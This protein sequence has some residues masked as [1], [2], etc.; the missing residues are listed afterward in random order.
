MI[1]LTDRFKEVNAL[2]EKVPSYIALFESK[3]TLRAECSTSSD[4]QSHNG[5]QS[6]DVTSSPGSVLLNRPGGI[7]QSD[8]SAGD[9]IIQDGTGN[10]Q[11]LWQSFTAPD[12]T[13]LNRVAFLMEGQASAGEDAACEVYD[14]NMN[15]LGSVLKNLPDDIDIQ[16][17]WV[18]FDFSGLNIQLA[19][20]ATYWLRLITDLDVPSAIIK[21]AYSS[22][23]PYAGGEMYLGSV[24]TGST[25][26]ACFYVTFKYAQSGYIVTKTLDLGKSPTVDGEWVFEDTVPINTSITYTAWASDTGAF[27]GEE[28]YLGT[29]E[30]GDPITVR[31][32]YYRVKAELSTQDLSI[33]PE[34]HSVAAYF[35]FFVKFA[36]HLSAGYEPV[37]MGISSLEASIHPFKPSTIGTISM[38]LART[39]STEDYMT[40]HNPVGKRV[41]VKAG[42]IHEGLTEDDYMLYY[43]GIID[44]YRLDG[45]GVFV[46]NLKDPTT[47]WKEKIPKKWESTADDISWGGVHPVDCMLDILERIGVRGAEIDKTSFSGVKAALPGWTVSRTLTGNTYEADRLLEELRLLTTTQFIPRGDGKIRL[48]LY[49]P[50]ESPV[51]E[52]TDQNLVN[53]GW[54]ANAEALLNELYVYYDWTGS[55]DEL[56]SFQ[57]LYILVDATSEKDWGPRKKEIKDRWT[58]AGNGW[59]TQQ[60]AQKIIQRFSKK[61]A[62]LEV[63]VDRSFLWLEVGDMVSV[64]STLPPGGLTQKK[65]QIIR[66][67]LDFSKETVRLR[68]LEV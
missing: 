10:R 40:G 38:R 3:D 23:N 64:T 63:E 49:D 47:S 34:L 24:G 30:D 46:V 51:A 35:P 31:K 11:P 6:V 14:A 54:D 12:N 67:N 44:R 19:S 4:W 68:L 58:Q 52:F 50:E 42:F 20:G 29:I 56:S 41:V 8:S 22:S 53:I 7:Q 65:F 61:P 15:Y 57:R 9:V 21:V 26:D 59:Q 48:K 60:M 33:T 37:I 32:R 2:L 39:P 13:A 36:S 27:G 25:D 17:L 18:E 28:V 5:A 1:A 62:L 43:T 45:E 16:H 55:G 66:K